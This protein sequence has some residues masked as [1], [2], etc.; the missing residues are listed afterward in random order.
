M[1]LYLFTKYHSKRRKL[2]YLLLQLGCVE[3]Q[4]SWL[5]P[6]I[7]ITCYKDWDPEGFKFEHYT[8][9]TKITK[10]VSNQPK[11]QEYKRA[12][13]CLLICVPNPHSKL[14]VVMVLLKW[15]WVVGTKFAYR[16]LFSKMLKVR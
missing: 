9:N 3:A 6:K 14:K 10:H 5:N 15:D 7:F 11:H 2:V 13:K 4:T 8:K 1:K 16:K 12:N